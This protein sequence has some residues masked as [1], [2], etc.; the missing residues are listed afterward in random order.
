MEGAKCTNCGWKGSK[1]Q[2]LITPTEYNCPKCNHNTIV[3]PKI[4]QPKK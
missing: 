3:I 1:Y 4:S 2:V